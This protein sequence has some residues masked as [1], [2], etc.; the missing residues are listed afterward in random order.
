MD[1]MTGTLSALLF[2]FL[3][4]TAISVRDIMTMTIPDGASLAVGFVGIVIS[5]LLPFP[6]FYDAALGACFGFLFSYILRDFHYRIRGYHGLGMGDVKLISA[7]GCWTG[8]EGL[9]P[10]LSV[11]ALSGLFACGT[12]YLF[13]NPVH[14]RDRVPFGPFLC[15]GLA[16]VA[17]VQMIFGASIYAISIPDWLD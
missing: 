16:C 13:G 17:S 14:R 12:I 15:I 2:L 7:A 4:L 8:L 9:P 10:M 3:I 1:Q 6:G 11:A 5:S